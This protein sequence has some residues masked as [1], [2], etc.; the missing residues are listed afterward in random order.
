M[1]V[2]RRVKDG[3]RLLIGFAVLAIIL[4]VAVPAMAAGGKGHDRIGP[5]VIGYDIVHF[6]AKG[7]KPG[8]PGGGG[9]DPPSTPPELRYVLLPGGW[10]TKGAPST[11]TYVVEDPGIAG[12]VDTVV[13]GFNVWNAASGTNFMFG[14][15]Q[16][17]NVNAEFSAP[18]TL[19]TVS[20]A[21]LTGSWSNALA[22]TRIWIEETGTPNGVWDPGEPIIGN[23]MAFN[24]KY[25]WAVAEDAPKGKW[26]DIQNVAGHEAGHFVGLDDQFQ[27][28][29]QTMYGSAG[30]KQTNKRSLEA[31]DI[32]GARALYGLP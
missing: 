13:A 5:N 18:N 1:P 9:D 12:A 28:A 15:T 32:A 17:V 4:A 29:E 11:V 8:R 25:K 19:H 2:D 6:P 21:L 7:G 30:S 16:D 3:E 22:V 23:D 20:W 24:T 10:G 27:W 26:Y 14:G 31:G